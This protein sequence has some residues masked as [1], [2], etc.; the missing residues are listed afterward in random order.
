MIQNNSLLILIISILVPI[1]FFY[2]LNYIAE[3]LN[4][5]DLPDNKLKTHKHKVFAGGGII[6]IILTMIIFVFEL[7]LLDTNFFFIE[8]TKSF[9][10][11]NFSCIMIFFLGLYDD[12]YK[13]HYRNKFLILFI[14]IVFNLMLDESLKVKSL[15]FTFLD[16]PIDIK[17]LQVLFTV[18]CILAYINA[19][20]L[21]DG[22]DLQS[23]TYIVT[24]FLIFI[25]IYKE[26][27]FAYYLFGFFLFLI[28]NFK[29]KIFLGNSGSLLF[30]FLISFFLI[31]F[32]NYEYIKSDE[33]FLLM[34]IP[35]LDMLRLFF[36]RLLKKKNPFKGDKNHLHHLISKKNF[37]FTTYIIIQLNIILP[38]IAYYFFKYSIIH[39][40]FF[41]IFIYLLLIISNLKSNN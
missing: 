13:L 31:K 24:I 17:Y 7:L 33:I 2:N 14:I 36:L 9:I 39:S 29:K 38:I 27:Y 5:F 20:N 30:G 18:F 8:N 35:G 26:I 34:M 32:H 1:I 6:F 15:S 40:I 41:G 21:F 19:L 10:A 37:F 22:I 11:F 12:K 16:K 28:F 4:V 25:F 23:G 3:K